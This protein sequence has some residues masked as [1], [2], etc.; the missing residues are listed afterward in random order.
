M[1]LQPQPQAQPQVAG[2]AGAAGDGASRTES[3]SR[4]LAAV[5]SGAGATGADTASAAAGA[6]APASIRVGGGGSGVRASIGAGAGNGTAVDSMWHS[7]DLGPLHVV[8]LSSESYFYLTPHGL[9][10]LAQ[11]YAWLEAD[12]AAVNRSVTPWV[13]AMSHRPCY[14]S[15]NDDGDDCHSA[16]SVLRDGILGEYGLEALLYKY[17]VDVFFGAHEHSYE[18]NYPVYQVRRAA[19]AGRPAGRRR[20]AA[21]AGPWSPGRV[22]GWGGALRVCPMYCHAG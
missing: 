13:I 20:R 9:G 4:K 18:R 8:M 2:G 1:P 14:C 3:L 19:R 12:L 22:V 5:L 17:G 7:L 15:P 21:A 6:A 10:L 16:T 11:Q